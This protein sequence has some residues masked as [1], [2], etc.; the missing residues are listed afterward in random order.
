MG[1]AKRH[2][3]YEYNCKI[4]RFKCYCLITGGIET[5]GGRVRDPASYVENNEKQRK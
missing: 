2:E 4:W 5:N 1:T 3:K